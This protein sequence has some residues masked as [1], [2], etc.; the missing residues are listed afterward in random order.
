MG[1][2]SI[3][4]ANTLNSMSISYENKGEYKKARDCS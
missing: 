3:E 2:N 1:N 4:I